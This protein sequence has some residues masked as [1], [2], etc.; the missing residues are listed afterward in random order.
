V[1]KVA[2][3]DELARVA[4]PVFA[5]ALAGTPLALGDAWCGVLAFGLQIY[6][7]FSGYSDMAIG[8]ALLFGFTLP[9]N[10]NAPYRAVSL[11]DF[12]RRW[13]ITLSTFLRDYLYFALGGAR[14]GPARQ[15]LALMGTM[16]LGGLWHG[17]AWTFVL[18]G[19]LHGAGL[20]VNHALRR[21]DVRVPAALGIALTFAFVTLAWIPF[22][23][24]DF[25]SAAHLF[26]ALWSAAGAPA[27]DLE[28]TWVL[29]PALLLAVLG[30]TSQQIAHAILVPGRALAVA[31]GIALAVLTVATGGWRT[32]EFIY[33]Q[34]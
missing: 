24:A 10:F 22:R 2:F 23:A 5:A 25:A 12:W 31:T 32:P 34:F 14:H 3:A 28:H 17:A 6:F 19:G 15:A 29:L 33:F 30:P 27:L 11:I 18:W 8:L 16:L 4:D 21:I 13:H 26:A 1:K 7:D 20:C 9:V